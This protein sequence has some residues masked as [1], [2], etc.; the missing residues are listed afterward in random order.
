MQILEEA[1]F[2][3][4]S[5]PVKYYWVFYSGA[6]PFVVA[7][8]YFAAD[9]SRSSHAARDAWGVSF[10]IVLLY[11]WMR[12]CQAGFCVGL[13]DTLNPEGRSEKKGKGFANVAA[14][15]FIQA[16]HIPFLIFGAFFAIPLGWII[17]TLQNVTVL[18]RNRDFGHRTLRGMLSESIRLSHF[19]WA[20]NHG[21]LLVFGFIGLFTWIN[22]VATCVMIPTF[23]KSF[24]GVESV[25]TVNPLVAVMNTTF[26]SGTLLLTYLI[27]SP[28]LKA[29]YTLRCFY[30][31]SRATGE[32]LLSRLS[33]CR[34]RRKRERSLSSGQLSKVAVIVLLVISS[35][36]QVL[37]ENKTEKETDAFREELIETM[38]QKKYQWQLS[39]RDEML[40]N[41]EE[42]GWLSRR[43]REVAEQARETIRSISDWIENAI[44][45]MQ[46]RQPQPRSNDDEDSIWKNLK[47]FSSTL[48]IALILVVG[49]LLFW[50]L[51]SFY[52]KYRDSREVELAAESGIEAIDLQSEDIVAS[53]LPEQEWMRLA[54]EQIQRGEGRLAIRALFLATL[55][56]LGEKDLIR[57]ARFKSNRDYWQELQRRVRS[58]T[59]MRRSFERN[60]LLFE[61][62]WYGAHEVED[63]MVDEFLENHSTIVERS[64]AANARTS[65][66]LAGVS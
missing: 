49:A 32:D 34:T 2:L 59:A 16:F 12:F 29:A 48:S 7:L 64:E 4:R 1:F 30:A 11:F 10:V 53:Q 51:R 44:D 18:A 52:L 20:Q 6:V 37:A 41:G 62:T 38:E 13:W 61:E 23:A 65:R 9:M 35:L 63:V 33:D 66:A 28:M 15:C 27:I 36:N 19:E 26:I 60:T 8:L 17:A 43:I 21:V 45:R 31:E 47:D 5:V 39:R 56:N 25:F 58:D 22:I 57:I 50:L 3:L 40:A 54:Q 14:L 46:N 42:E 24:F 55:A